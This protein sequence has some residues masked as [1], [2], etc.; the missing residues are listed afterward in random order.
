MT[1]RR[2]EGC[3]EI[4]L[5][6]EKVVQLR[7]ASDAEIEAM[8]GSSSQVS[9]LLCTGQQLPQQASSALGLGAKPGVWF[10]RPQP[11]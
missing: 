7:S 3:E 6:V 11:N 9:R 4:G 1:D 2:A 10:C 5:V 8:M